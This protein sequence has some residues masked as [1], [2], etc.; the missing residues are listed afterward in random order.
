MYNYRK[1]RRFKQ[2]ISRQECIEVLK[3][4]PRGILSMHGENGFPYSVPIN[5]YYDE[6]NGKLYFH[7]AKEGLKLDLLRENNKV[8]FTI[9]D[10]GY[11]IEGQWPMHFHSVICLGT[12]HEVTD[13]GSF[14]NHL[15]KLGNKYYPSEEDVDDL[16]SKTISRIC[17]YEMD[18]ERM[19]GKH[20]K[21]S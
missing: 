3:N 16:I 6:E 19:T 12:I 15:R 1:M 8:C 10:E 18:I 13:Q 20:V 4:A 17:L 9:I 2:E 21:E 5:Q 11:Q 7:G 14:I